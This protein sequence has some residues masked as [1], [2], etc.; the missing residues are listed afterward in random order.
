MDQIGKPIEINR[1]F[2]KFIE[3]DI[4]PEYNR[5]FEMLLQKLKDELDQKYTFEEKILKK[6]DYNKYKNGSDRD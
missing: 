3:E 5:V 1:K 4:E 6:E 2:I